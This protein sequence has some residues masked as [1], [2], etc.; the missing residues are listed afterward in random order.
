MP[1]FE[2]YTL[3]L[4]GGGRIGICPL[5]GR[6][7]SIES[8]LAT[9]LTWAPDKILS[10]TEQFEMDAAG[11]GELGQRFAARGIEWIHFPVRDYGGPADEQAKSWP[12]ISQLLHDSLAGG[13]SVLLHCFG[14][15]G[16][17][18]MIALRLLA[19]RGEEPAE[20]LSRIRAIRPGAVE[21]DEQYAW[22]ASGFTGDNRDT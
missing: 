12:A 10:M 13:G 19:E 3:N 4:K 8:D 20:A 9:I 22:A 6:Y 18:G 15:Q 11:A 16:R 7:S 5:P 1:E 14:G 2:I 17:S 21:T